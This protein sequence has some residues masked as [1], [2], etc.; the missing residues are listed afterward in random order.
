MNKK[1]IETEQIIVNTIRDIMTTTMN[2]CGV[3]ELILDKLGL[4]EDFNDE[5][6]LISRI[7]VKLDNKISISELYDISRKSAVKFINSYLGD[8]IL[9][10]KLNHAFPS[11]V[12]FD[13]CSIK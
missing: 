5:L 7:A 9:V 3:N 4:T 2:E 1:Q 6:Y 10:N 8:C 13:L 12:K 11:N